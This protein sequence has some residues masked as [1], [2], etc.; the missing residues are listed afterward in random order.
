MVLMAESIAAPLI[1]AA[2]EIHRI[3]CISWERS[4]LD[5]PQSTALRTKQ[6]KLFTVFSEEQPVPY[7]KRNTVE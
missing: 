7:E 3:R 5:T 6:R 4:L 1:P 2:G